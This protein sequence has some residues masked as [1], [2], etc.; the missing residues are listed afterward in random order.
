MNYTQ[1]EIAL[2][3]LAQ[4]RLAINHVLRKRLLLKNAGLGQGEITPTPGTIDPLTMKSPLST[5]PTPRFGLPRGAS[6]RPIL[7][8]KRRE[9]PW[10]ENP[11]NFDQKHN[12][13]VDRVN[14]RFPKTWESL[15][16]TKINLIEEPENA[17][18]GFR[19]KNLPK[20][21]SQPASDW[22]WDDLEYELDS[23]KK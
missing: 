2:V 7:V 13:M 18:P 4:I 6:P 8:R 22:E 21:I 5:D 15:Q 23:N 17:I 3:K 16:P 20:L 11:K 10:D 1:N 14:K 12:K 9:L 19:M